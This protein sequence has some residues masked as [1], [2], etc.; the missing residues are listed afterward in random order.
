MGHLGAT[1]GTLTAPTGPAVDLADNVSQGRRRHRRPHRL[2]G[3]QPALERHAARREPRARASASRGSSI[4]VDPATEQPSST[5]RADFHQPVDDRH[6]AGPGHPGRD[7]R[8]QRPAPADP[9]DR[10]R[11]V[12]Q[13]DPAVG[14]VRPRRRPA[15][16]VARSAT[17][18]PTRCAT[19]YAS[20]GV[21]FAITNSGGLRDALTCPA[22]GGGTGFCPAATPPPFLITRGQ[23]LAVLPF[24]NVVAT[25]TINGAELKAF[26]ENGVSQ[27]PGAQRAVPAGL[28]PVLHVRH[29]GRR[30][31]AASP[32]RS[33]P[34]ADGTCSATPV[35][36]TAGGVVQ[37]RH[38]RLHGVRWRLLSDTSTRSPDTRRRRSWTRSSPT[39]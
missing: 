6:H 33:W 26:L 10:H 37:D 1:A 30:R 4:V 36:L 25:V 2:P 31:A 20:I 35:D 32:A 8:P 21:Q 23:V 27:M 16:R 28:R 9:R 13:G 29:R 14:P 3:A 12:D 22:A 17:S 18:S 7:R 15:V 24:G 39:T 38:Q 11:R 5:R 34:S 19:A